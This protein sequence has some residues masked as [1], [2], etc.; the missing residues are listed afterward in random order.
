MENK[1]GKKCKLRKISLI[2]PLLVMP[3]ITPFY[4]I[5]DSVWHIDCV[6]DCPGRAV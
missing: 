1:V 2:V 3:I 6:N 4:S 5:L